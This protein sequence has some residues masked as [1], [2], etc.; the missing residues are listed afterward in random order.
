MKF[1]TDTIKPQN[2]INKAIF[3]DRDGVIN[4]LICR[5]GKW[6]APYNLSEFELLP[7]V[8]ES[9]IQ[10]KNAGFI[11]IVVT[12]QPDM[13]R[14]WVSRENIDL[15]NNHILEVLPIDEI[16]VCFHIN[17]DNC[18]CRKPKPG[19]LIAASKTWNIDLE[20]SFLIGDRESDIRAGI[21]VG[22]KTILIDSPQQE[23]TINIKSDYTAKTMLEALK[24]ILP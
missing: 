1:L 9:L 23:K 21:A 14:G 7:G 2:N 6:Q 22:C 15:I 4:K 13:A 12:N 19:M 16:K 17:E 11:N 10:F 8:A 5:Q 20:N 24:F 18:D 3:L